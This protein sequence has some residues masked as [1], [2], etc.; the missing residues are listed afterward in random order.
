MS[1]ITGTFMRPYP[2]M[3]IAL[4]SDVYCTL[5]YSL[6][7]WEKERSKSIFLY[8]HVGFVLYNNTF[9]LHVVE[10]CYFTLS[11]KITPGFN[12]II[13]LTWMPISRVY[14][15]SVPKDVRAMHIRCWNATLCQNHVSMFWSKIKPDNYLVAVWFCRKWPNH[16]ATR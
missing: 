3:N 8:I 1:Q 12:H 5:D 6:Y 11:S 10:E 13:H 14:Q 9:C 2:K 4:S 15:N 16:T 7:P